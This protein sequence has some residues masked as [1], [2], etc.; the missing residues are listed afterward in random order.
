MGQLQISG[1]S[2]YVN[3]WQNPGDEALTS[4]PS[5]VYPANSYRETFYQGSEVRILKGD[6]I[7]LRDI[8]LSYDFSSLLN[9]KHI[10]LSAFAYG[11]NLAILWRKN[12][13]GIDPQMITGSYPTPKMYSF[14]F[15]ATF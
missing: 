5:L 1:Y 9:N 11:Q 7:R 13:E 3:R 15:N 12:K 14:G 4:V 6:H 10:R 2:D 8:R